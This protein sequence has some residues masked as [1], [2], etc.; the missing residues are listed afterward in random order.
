MTFT[1]WSGNEGRYFGEGTRAFIFADGDITADTPKQ[2]SDFLAKNPPKVPNTIVVLNSDGGDLGAGLDFGALIR[3]A[4]LWTEVGSQYPVTIPSSPNIPAAMTP[5]IARP[6]TPPFAGGCYSACTFAFLGGV[7]RSVP[8]AS[9]FG[10][11]R[12]EGTANDLSADAAQQM[13]GALVQYVREM[14]VAAQFVTEMSTASP[15]QINDLTLQKMAALKVITPHW[16]SSW[17][18]ATLND[19]SGFY[20]QDMVSDGWGTHEIAVSCFPHPAQ[21]PASGGQNQA[22]GTQSQGAGGKKSPV[23]QMTFF[24]DPGSRADLQTLVAAVRGY[25]LEF[26]GESIGVDP[27]IAY[28]AV[29]PSGTK[30]LAATVN[31]PADLLAALEQSAHIGFAF[32]F[33]ANANLPIRLL[34]FV[35]DLDVGQ[36]KSFRATCH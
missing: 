14:G 22:A 2:F 26:D 16:H 10:V 1:A 13:S 9:N 23:L 19:S 4:K 28:P 11:H 17:Q 33:D 12:F 32:I 18:I 25:V 7:V 35:S 3:K 20:L 30:W 29:I 27:L 8:Y 31:I 6:A 34:Q 15:S 24:L 36:L 5:F 21:T